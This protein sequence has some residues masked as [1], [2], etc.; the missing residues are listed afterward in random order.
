MKK[1]IFYICLLLSSLNCLTAQSLLQ[2]EDL[3][4]NTDEP[5]I[6]S[7]S[8]TFNYMQSAILDDENIHNIQ[9]IKNCPTQTNWYLMAYSSN[10]LLI[11]Q[12]EENKR[13]YLT[14]RLIANSFNSFTAKN[15][16]ILAKQIIHR[17]VKTSETITI[18]AS[19]NS[20][21]NIASEE[22]ALTNNRETK[23]IV[24]KKK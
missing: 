8:F 18:F 1:A 11:K 9:L 22:L 2:E 5:P 23:K 7:N 20:L 24:L 21:A 3:A 4:S 10:L 19:E 13:Y 6:Y 17:F 12:K 14:Y 15:I 16:S